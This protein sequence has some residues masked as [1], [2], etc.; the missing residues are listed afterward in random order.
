[1][2]PRFLASI[3]LAATLFA[4]GAC[5]EMRSVLAYRTPIY[6]EGAPEVMPVEACL[7]SVSAAILTNTAWHPML[8][9]TELPKRFAVQTGIHDRAQ[10]I[11]EHRG[12]LD[13]YPGS[14]VV[15]GD[16]SLSNVVVLQGKC[17]FMPLIKPLAEAYDA[18]KTDQERM[19]FVRQIKK[20]YL[21]EKNS[22][23]F[24]KNP[25]II[26]TT[27]SSQAA[28]KGKSFSIIVDSNHVLDFGHFKLDKLRPSFSLIRSNVAAGEGYRYMAVTGLD[29]YENA[30]KMHFTAAA[31]DVSGNWVK[32][33]TYIPTEAW[34]ASLHNGKRL[35]ASVS[36]NRDTMDVFVTRYRDKLKQKMEDPAFKRRYLATLEQQNRQIGFYWKSQ[37]VL[38]QSALIATKEREFTRIF[39][40]VNPIKYWVGSF[41]VPVSGVITSGFGHHR[42]YYGGFSSVHRAIDIANVMG[43][44]IHAP[45]AGKIVYVGNTPDRGNNIVIDHGLGVYTCL[46]HLSEMFVEKGDVVRKNDTI[47]SLGNTGLSSGP[48]VHWEMVVNGRRVNPLDWTSRKY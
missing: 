25:F 41:S 46:F 2:I 12:I 22:M 23:L 10:I 30:D 3:L 8:P 4:F 34:R 48:H 43:T 18:L 6:I 16:C 35:E 37:Q 45:N 31:K 21:E 13:V 36:P 24:V 15:I 14:L 9:Y 11:M 42:W 26:E 5:E 38:R 19:V 17:A 32:M 40:T 39:N 1:M 27:F 7:A 44:H 33:R 20:R 29:I 28:P 47:A